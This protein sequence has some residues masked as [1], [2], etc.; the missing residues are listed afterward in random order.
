MTERLFQR[1]ASELQRRA[2]EQAANWYLDQ[3]EGLDES[4]Q[5]EFMAWLRQSPRHM[6]EYLAIAGLHGDLGAA[7]AL[8]PLDQGQLC[9]L[10]ANEHAVTPLRLSAQADS[11]RPRRHQPRWPGR[12]LQAAAAALVLAL[13]S[14]AWLREPLQAWD[15]Y[16]ADVSTPRSVALPDGTW[17]QIDRG[18]V[19]TVRMDAQQRQIDVLRGGAMF[20][21]GHDPS[22]PLRVQLGA[23][24]LQD[25]GTVF[26]AHR[27]DD[28]A[29]VTVVSGHVKVWQSSDASWGAPDLPLGTRALADLGAGQ[30]ANMHRDGSLNLIVR[31]ADLAESTA[32]LPTDIHFEHASVAEVARRFNAYSVKPLVIDDT[33]IGTTRISGRFHARDVEAFIAYLHSMP[34]VRVI[35]GDSDI[36][37]VVANPASAG[38]RTL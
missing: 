3:R 16:T 37:I 26:D 13:G 22:R 28:G 31:H 38:A 4:Q 25:I 30:Q 9:E 18:S 27:A 6:T 32:W 21:V 20:D 14:A 1:Q 17:L 7:A 19:L 8:D 5:V 35:R 24:V 12:A 33:R 2:T 15:A 34:G 29:R 10:A 36:R 23:D 11:A